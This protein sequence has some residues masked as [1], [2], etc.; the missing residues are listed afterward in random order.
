MLGIG[1]T[2]MSPTT[3]ANG[4]PTAA[5]NTAMT[6][7]LLGFIDEALLAAVGGCEGRALACAAAQIEASGRLAEWSEGSA[8][9]GAEE[10]RL[11]PGG[12]MAAPIDLVEVDQDAIG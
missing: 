12:E 4:A 3:P 10:L 5:A 9:F 2:F 1:R 7:S 8:E 6:K 11:F